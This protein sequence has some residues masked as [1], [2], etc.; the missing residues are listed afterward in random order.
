MQRELVISS[1]KKERKIISV[2]S[3]RQ[4]TI[5]QKYYDLLGFDNEAECVL[6]DDSIIIRP[7]Q[8]IN[9]SEFMKRMES[10]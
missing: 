10:L 7:M 3:K 2:S 6:Q 4:L 5:P 1:V 9:T 8:N